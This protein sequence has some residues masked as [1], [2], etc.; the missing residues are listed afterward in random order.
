MIKYIGILLIFF[1]CSYTGYLTYL[2]RHRRVK[3]IMGMLSLI[4]YIKQR[5]EFFSDPLCDIYASFQNDELSRCGYIKSLTENDFLF[6]FKKHSSDFGFSEETEAFVT[7]FA[8]SLGR[9]P[10][11]EHISSCEYLFS[12]VAEEEAR[13]RETLKK[14]KK[15]FCGIGVL[16]GCA[17]VVLLI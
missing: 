15:L 2:A 4:K 16:A 5:A 6:A 13:A 10:L 3:R 1:S 11:K 12:I 17:A 8:D 14:E 7:S 9:L